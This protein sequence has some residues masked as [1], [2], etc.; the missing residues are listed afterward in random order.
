MVNLY[1][2]RVHLDSWTFM[3]SKKSETS[4]L[5]RPTPNARRR[6]STP[7]EP[8]SPG[9]AATLKEATTLT[10]DA[11]PPEQHPLFRLRLMVVGCAYLIYSA[12]LGGVIF[13]RQQIILWLCITL[14]V[15]N[16]GKSRGAIERVVRDWAP[17][18]GVILAYD[19]SRGAADTLGFPVQWNL[20]IA[21]DEAIFGEVPAVSL[22]RW[23]DIGPQ[24]HWWEAITALVY[25]S[26]FF[27]TYIVLAAL[28]AKNRSLW[29]RYFRG[30]IVLSFSG[31]ATY[32]LLPTAPP[33][34]AAE[35]G[36]IGDIT[37]STTNGWRYLGIEI[38]DKVVNNGRRLSNDVA[39][40]PSLH[41]AFSALP[42]FMFWKASRPWLR[43]IM[44]VYPFAMAFSIV[45][46]GEH[47]VFDVL[48]GFIYAAASAALANRWANATELR[49]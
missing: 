1:V 31:I 38:A 12:L 46:S 13:E 44:V 40:L 7:V 5:L 23:L 16:L 22:Q 8:L 4:S 45:S 47:Y 10:I 32:I 18:F 9:A 30:F 3:G 29:S 39:A 42:L 11:A 24:A 48:M 20:P 28:W 43:A 2:N 35:Q 14:I 34:L 41:L 15:A 17:M 27:L 37:R 25:V 6:D 49:H 19:Y 21:F 33:W 26:H 36:L